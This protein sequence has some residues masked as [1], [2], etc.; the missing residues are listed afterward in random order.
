MSNIRTI[1]L[2]EGG[3]DIVTGILRE[4]RRAIRCID[5]PPEAQY[6]G[7]CDKCRTPMHAREGETE[8]RC[9]T[10]GTEFAVAERLAKINTKVQSALLSLREIADLS[11]RHFGGKITL[12]Q[13]EGLVRRRRLAPAGSRPIPGGR[14]E[15]VQLYRAGDVVELMSERVAS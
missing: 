4:H 14:H 11:E 9:A 3:P 12:K 15:F 7:L 13:L 2:D 10:C 6:I 8:H 1:A 5:R